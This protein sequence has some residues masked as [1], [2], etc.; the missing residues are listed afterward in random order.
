[1]EDSQRGAARCACPNKTHEAKFIVIT[2]GP[3]GGKTALLELARRYL[4]R[5]VAVLPEAAGIVSGGG[6]PRRDR[7]ESRRAAQRAIFHVQREI[8]RAMQEEDDAAIV[9]CDRGTLDS[10]AYWPGDPGELWRDVRSSPDAELSRYAMVIHMRT[11]PD[12]EY[13]HRNPLRTETVEEAAEIDRRIEVVWSGHPRRVIVEHRVD[14][15]D[16]AQEALRLVR[17]EL[18]SCCRPG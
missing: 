9:L 11:P 4:C 14:F 5:H 17:A 1:M 16:K 13:N 18:P 2:G 8:E 7:F 10:A 3:G 15:L 6:F 12:G